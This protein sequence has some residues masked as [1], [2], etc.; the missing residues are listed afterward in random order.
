MSENDLFLF[1]YTYSQ[2]DGVG[3][4]ASLKKPTKTFI[5]AI[6]YK[7]IFSISK[8]YVFNQ[9]ATEVK[10]TSKYLVSF[11]RKISKPFVYFQ[12]FSD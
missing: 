3:V 12:F 9:H 8:G 7:V 5:C 11:D 1:L 10:F 6:N 2:G 4:F